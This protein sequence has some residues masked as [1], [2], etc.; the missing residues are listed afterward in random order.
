M[1]PKFGKY[2]TGGVGFVDEAAL[3]NHAAP[4]DAPRRVATAASPE[5]I[6]V[7]LNEKFAARRMMAFVATGIFVRDALTGIAAAKAADG[8]LTVTAAAANGFKMTI[9]CATPNAE[10]C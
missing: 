5:S 10:S 8:R 7:S 3:R 9:T 1:T 2:R 4:A 6:A